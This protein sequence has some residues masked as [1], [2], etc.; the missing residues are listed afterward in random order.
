MNFR[1]RLTALLLAAA[2]IASGSAIAFAQ[3]DEGNNSPHTHEY[4]VVS[5]SQGVVSYKCRYCGDAFSEAFAS[6]LN[7]RNY[8]PLDV[9]ADGVINAKDYAFLINH[10][11]S[12]GPINGYDDGSGSW[13]IPGID[14]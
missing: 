13:E 10:Y 9:V 11:D 7:E 5:F 6:R 3:P 14:I 1:K 4:H 2:V 12:F 8:A